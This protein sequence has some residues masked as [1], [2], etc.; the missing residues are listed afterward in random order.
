MASIHVH[1]E[2]ELTRGRRWTTD[3]VL[4]PKFDTYKIVKPG[5]TEGSR[6]DSPGREGM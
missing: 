2:E 4:E 6:L 1:L 3:S 5:T